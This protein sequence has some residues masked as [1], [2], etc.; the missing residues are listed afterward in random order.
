[1]IIHVDDINDN[2][3]EFVRPLFTGG[4]TTESDYGAEVITVQVSQGHRR[5][6]NRVRLRRRGHHCTGQSG[7]PEGSQPS[8]TTAPRSSLYRSVRVTG[9]VTTESD[10][11]AEVITV[12]VSQGHRRGHNRV[13]L[14]RRGHHC[15]GQSGSPEGSQPS[16]TTAPRS[17]PYRSVRVT[18][19]VT[20]ESDYGAEVITVQVSQGHRR[21]HNESDYGAEVITVQVSQGHRRGH[22]RVRLRRRGH[23]CTGQ[24]GSPE[25]SQPSPTTAPRSSPCRSVRVTGGVTTES[26]YGAEVIT[27]QVSQGHRR[28]HNRVRLRRRGHH[29]TGQSGSPEGSQPSPTTAPRS[30]PYRSVRVTG[31]VTT[32]SDY[33]AEVITVQVSQGHRRGHN[34]V[35]L[36]RRGHH[37]TGQSG[38]PE[39]LQPSPTTAP[40]SSLYRSVRVTWFNRRRN[41]TGGCRVTWLQRGQHGIR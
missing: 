17:S 30:S 21:G 4:V 10:Y 16:P 22:N 6:H 11:G 19:G 18:G 31:G 33:G 15:T 13:R 29:R 24:S 34:R 32:E 26:D 28:G 9:G 41:R 1:M 20:T 27:V 39:G 25:G 12:Q 40:R 23:H 14:R 38:S 3:P 7:S 36:R 2:Q 35:R 37:C 5:G 8:P